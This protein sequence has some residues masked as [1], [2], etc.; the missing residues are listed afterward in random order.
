MSVHSHSCCDSCL[1]S[2]TP[3]SVC[4]FDKYLLSAC[5]VLSSLPGAQD[6][7][8]DTTDT[9]C[10]GRWSDTAGKL[11]SLLRGQRKQDQAKGQL[12]KSHVP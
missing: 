9:A 5:D 1:V 4:P 8:G 12:P 3:P 2:V 7:T 10:R 6:V 11:D